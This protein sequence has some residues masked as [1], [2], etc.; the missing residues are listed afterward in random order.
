MNFGKFFVVD[1]VGVGHA[2]FVGA[3]QDRIVLQ[4][5]IFVE[6]VDRIKAETGDAAFVPETRLVKHRFLHGRIAPI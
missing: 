6:R 1:L 5:G 2:E 4:V 3:R